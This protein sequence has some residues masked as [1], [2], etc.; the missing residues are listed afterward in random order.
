MKNGMP[1][2]VLQKFLGHS[3]LHI[4]GFYQKFAAQ[5]THEAMAKVMR[6][7]STAHR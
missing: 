3:S 5:D 7:E 4:T 1:I 6:T 2:A